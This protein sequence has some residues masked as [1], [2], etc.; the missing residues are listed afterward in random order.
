MSVQKNRT[1]NIEFKVQGTGG[2]IENLAECPGK[3]GG[4]PARGRV[5]TTGYELRDAMIAPDGATGL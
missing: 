1:S 5:K 3:P 4:I 2:R